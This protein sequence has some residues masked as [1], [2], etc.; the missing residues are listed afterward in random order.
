MASTC[1]RV[2]A[3]TRPHSLP[4]SRQVR[5]KADT[6][7]LFL[8][9]AQIAGRL[10]A[11]NRVGDLRVARLLEFLERLAAHRGVDVQVADADDGAE[12][13]EHEEDDAVVNHPAPVALSDQILFFV[14][15]AGVGERRFRI[16]L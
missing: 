13:L 9:P 15:Q 11:G 1:G 3:K 7:Y 4:E 16:R 14:G 10:F 2:G 5:L 12:L 8:V 6:T